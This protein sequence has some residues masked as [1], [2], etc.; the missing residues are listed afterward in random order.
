MDCFASLAMT[1]IMPPSIAFSRAL[2]AFRTAQDF[3]LLTQSLTP[4]STRSRG[5]RPA[6][7]HRNSKAGFSGANQLYDCERMV[8]NPWSCLPEY[9]QL[10]SVNRRLAVYPASR[11]LRQKRDMVA[12]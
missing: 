7:T 11:Q 1:G 10:G 5:G 12:S 2:R 4:A 6:L 9:R 3:Q 8:F